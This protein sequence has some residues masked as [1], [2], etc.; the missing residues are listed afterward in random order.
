MRPLEDRRGTKLPRKH[1]RITFDLSRNLLH[2]TPAPR[3]EER[4]DYWYHEADQEVASQPLLFAI[5][6][7][8][9]TKMKV[10]VSVHL[11][12]L[13]G[14]GFKPSDRSSL[15]V[16]TKQCP[17]GFHCGT[18]MGATSA[19]INVPLPKGVYILRCVGNQELIVSGIANHLT[20]PTLK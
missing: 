17:R 16:I 9:A 14:G 20:R 7:K 11:Q 12:C 8:A 10:G 6:A 4:A 5:K 15:V 19:R 18:V 13:I 3:P 1:P 2:E